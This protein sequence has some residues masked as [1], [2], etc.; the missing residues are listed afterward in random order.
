MNDLLSVWVVCQLLVVG[1]WC[2]GKSGL[3]VVA[4]TLNGLKNLWEIDNEE[5]GSR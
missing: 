1:R 4:S 3:T 5:Y 2:C